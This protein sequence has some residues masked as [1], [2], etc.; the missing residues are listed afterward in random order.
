MTLVC[1]AVVWDHAS[2][3][4][5]AWEEGSNGPTPLTTTLR[6]GRLIANLSKA[7]PPNRHAGPRRRAL[8][9]RKREQY[10][11]LEQGRSPGQQYQPPQGYEQPYSGDYQYSTAGDFSDFFEQMFGSRGGPSYHLRSLLT[12]QSA[13]QK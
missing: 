4:T 7:Q 3:S 11:P 6:S 12:P 8:A 13:L 9:W 1:R 10:D 5:H 2:S